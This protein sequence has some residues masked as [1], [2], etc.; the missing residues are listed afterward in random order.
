MRISAPMIV[1]NEAATIEAALRSLRPHVDEIVIVDTGSTD[2]T[3]AI[4]ECVAHAEGCPI[5]LHHEP[6]RAD[7]G[8]H[9]NHVQSLVTGDWIFYIDGDEYVDGGGE[10]IR[11]AI[12]R[13][14][15]RGDVN[16]VASLIL[17]VG[18][19]GGREE[20]NLIRIYKPDEVSWKYPVHNQ[21]VGLK[22]TV[23]FCDVVIRTSYVGRMEQ[24]MAR[25]VPM[26]EKLHAENTLD[27]HAAMFLAKTYAAAGQAEKTV[28]W[29]RH[30]VEVAGDSKPHAMAWVW[31]AMG[32]SKLG[33]FEEA[34]HILDEGLRRHP[35]MADLHLARV[36][37]QMALWLRA[38]NDPG[39]YAF[40]SQ[41]SLRLI[42]PESVDE[43]FS[44]LSVFGLNRA[45]AGVDS[46]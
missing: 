36:R 34:D 21:M 27:P 11:P 31:L 22:P 3:Q 45:P 16:A 10:T 8:W 38:S 20:H 12:E 1:R 29:A 6:W 42:A 43:L 39:H 9:R 23:E 26:L 7:F 13:A 30:V 2:G 15:K 4:I 40:A 46:A 14:E 33:K 5:H 18:D 17:S 28:P 25:S 44:A 35:G 24:K 32:L 41:E 19:N 37:C